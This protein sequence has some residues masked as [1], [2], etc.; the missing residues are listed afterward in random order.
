M[1]VYSLCTRIAY[2]HIIMYIC[3]ESLYAYRALTRLVYIRY[4][5]GTC[6]VYV[7]VCGVRVHVVYY[8]ILCTYRG[9]ICS[10]LYIL[11]NCSEI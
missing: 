6:I 7:C 3:V 8:R 2:V 9:K 1:C 10:R 11:S 5:V 4:S